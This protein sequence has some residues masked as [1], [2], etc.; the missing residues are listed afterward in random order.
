MDSDK[1]TKESKDDSNNAAQ[2]SPKFQLA[3]LDEDES[4]TDLANQ[5][6]NS[7]TDDSSSR[8]GGGIPSRQV[9][10][11]FLAIFTV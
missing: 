11:V 5:K 7:L 4:Q 1:S 3:C 10:I 2:R 8:S 6:D 9:R